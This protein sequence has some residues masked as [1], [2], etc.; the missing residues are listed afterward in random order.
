LAASCSVTKLTEHM[1]AFCG[2]MRRQHINQRNRVE[3]L[4]P[5]LDWKNL[6]IE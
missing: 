6:R 1:F 3:H 5:V 4:R 2:K